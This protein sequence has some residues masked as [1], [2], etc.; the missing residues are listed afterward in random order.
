MRG[1][2]GE[3]WRRRCDFELEGEGSPNSTSTNPA[4]PG[5][6]TKNGMN[7]QSTS[8]PPGT[9]ATSRT[10]IPSAQAG[11]NTSWSDKVA[12]TNPFQCGDGKGEQEA[13]T[14]DDIT[15]AEGVTDTQVREAFD[16]LK[17]HQASQPLVKTNEAKYSHIRACVMMRNLDSLHDSIILELPWGGEYIQEVDYTGLPDQCHRC[18]QRGHWA[19]DCPARNDKQQAPTQGLNG[20][21]GGTGTSA[22]PEVNQSPVG[23][24]GYDP[25]NDGFRSAKRKGPTRAEAMNQ[26]GTGLNGLNDKSVNPFGVLGMEEDEEDPPD[27]QE[28]LDSAPE[29]TTQP[30]S[31]QVL[32]E[33]LEEDDDGDED[34]N[35]GNQS[36]QEVKSQGA[37]NKNGAEEANEDEEKDMVQDTERLEVNEG[38]KEEAYAK[39]SEASTGQKTDE[40]R[41]AMDQL[42]AE[43]NNTEENQRKN[44]TKGEQGGGY[45]PSFA[46]ED[47]PIG[48]PVGR[49]GIP[50][51]IPGSTPKATTVEAQ[52][53][54]HAGRKSAPRFVMAPVTRQQSKTTCGCEA[55][56]VQVTP[57]RKAVE[58]RRTL[59]DRSALL[60]RAANLEDRSR[61]RRQ[62]NVGEGN[63]LENIPRKEVADNL[64]ILNG[65][66]ISTNEALAWIHR[67][68]PW[69]VPNP[70]DEPPNEEYS[71]NRSQNQPRA[72]ESWS[73]E[74]EP[75]EQEEVYRVSNQ[76]ERDGSAPLGV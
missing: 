3:G 63:Y 20:G 21:T 25:D 22:A 46:P 53:G 31:S 38:E 6:Y 27:Q 10:Q 59:E 42:W 24:V 23:G 8:Q 49:Q 75:Q 58:K 55:E 76:V 50:R 41:R 71:S 34:L 51:Y 56:N 69:N 5:V 61:A 37:E 36:N 4:G 60:L 64:D 67:L 1:R 62:S 47:K 14:E 52:H 17:W 70:N 29:A 65:N 32:V 44:Q 74:E 9:S 48:V 73:Q 35:A 72:N 16:E 18:R 26:R 11:R 68:D 33:R 43:Q 45:A 2:G 12:G 30:N 54:G 39:G 28:P 7:S 19:K 15:W 57:E 40:V 13:I 66:V